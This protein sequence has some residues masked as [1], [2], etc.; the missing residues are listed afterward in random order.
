M[1]LAATE[2]TEDSKAGVP[3]TMQDD[4]KAVESSVSTC[5]KALPPLAL[6]LV[7]R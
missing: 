2:T 4:P 3:P 5:T 6:D 7:V 1:M